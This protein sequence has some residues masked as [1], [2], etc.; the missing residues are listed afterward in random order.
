[1]KDDSSLSHTRWNCKYHIVFIPKYRRKEIYGKLREDIGAILRRLCEMKDVEI[2]EAHACID[3]IH[4]L[5]R[6]PPKMSVSSYVGYL[7]GKSALQIFERHANLKYKYGNRSFWSKGYYVSTVGLNE[8]TIKKYIK[9]Q[10]S[11]DRLRD[12]MTKREYVEPFKG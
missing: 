6:I 1:M 11:E 3:H 4:M 8:K 10:E 2:I 12:E 5:V 7:K 9:E